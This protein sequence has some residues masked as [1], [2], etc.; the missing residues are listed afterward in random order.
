MRAA[1]SLYLMRPW[2]SEVGHDLQSVSQQQAYG[3]FLSDGSQCRDLRFPG[4]PSSRWMVSVA[5]LLEKERGASVISRR[6]VRLLP[7][8][9]Q[10]WISPST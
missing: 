9:Q 6:L 10:R 8:L 4:T 3:N 7:L 1:W 2:I 5:V